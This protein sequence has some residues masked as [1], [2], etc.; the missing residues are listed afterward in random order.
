VLKETASPKDVEPHLAQKNWRPTPQNYLEKI[1]QIPFSLRP[2]TRTGYGKLVEGL[3]AASLS[4]FV[5]PGMES[6]SSP[7]S[8]PPGYGPGT[9]FTTPPPSE[10]TSTPPPGSSSSPSGGATDAPREPEF[11]IHD[12]SM[13]IRPVE[14]AFAKRLFDLLP[15]PRA[16]KRFSNTYRLLKAPI[17][18]SQLKAFEGSED[19]LGTFQVPMLL[20]AILTGMPGEAAKMFPALYDRVKGANEF[21]DLPPSAILEFASRDLREKI[22]SIVQ[23]DTF[24]RSPVL[25]ADWLRRVSRFSF[26]IGRAIKPA[27]SLR[28]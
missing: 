5:P 11:T 27:T 28:N 13:V 8:P 19:A 10:G 22:S 15:T 3:F 4:G 6:T 17:P 7:P 26:E 20:L 1:F 23:S 14:E 25:F 18:R 21:V 9:G 12:E 16:T 2:M 24:P